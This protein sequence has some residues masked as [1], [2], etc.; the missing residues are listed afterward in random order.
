MNEND[1]SKK[2]EWDFYNLSGKTVMLPCVCGKCKGDSPV[3]PSSH[4]AFID[5]NSMEILICKTESMQEEKIDECW[6][7]PEETSDKTWIVSLD[8][9]ELLERE[10][11]VCAEA[12]RENGNIVMKSLSER[13]KEIIKKKE[14]VK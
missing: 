9:F 12:C 7:F 4:T 10:D 14:T 1:N 11:V 2:K 5:E 8:V 6:D 3:E 13:A